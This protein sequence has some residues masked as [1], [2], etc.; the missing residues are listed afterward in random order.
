M[1]VTAGEPS[2]VLGYWLARCGGLLNRWI[3]EGEL[4]GV[5]YNILRAIAQ[6]VISLV[7]LWQ[8][9]NSYSYAVKWTHTGRMTCS[10]SGKPWGLGYV[11]GTVGSSCHSREVVIS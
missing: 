6:R 10:C 5:W 7:L 4:V 1:Y 3:E 9:V 8:R 11:Y 2:E